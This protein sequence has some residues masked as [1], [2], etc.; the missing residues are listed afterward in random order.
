M[1]YKLTIKRLLDVLFSFFALLIL[2]PIFIIVTIALVISTRGYP[3]FFQPRPGKNGK[4]FKIIKFKT[5]NEKC[6]SSGIILNDVERLTKIGKFLRKTSFDE[7]PQIINILSGKMSLIGPRPLLIEYISLYDDIQIR[8]LE[9]RPG[10]TGWAQVNG[11][12]AISWE[13]KFAYDIY[14]IDNCTFSLDFI[15][16]LKTFN[17]VIKRAD[18][19]K[20]TLV[21]MDLFKGTKNQSQ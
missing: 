8:R 7:L 5:M 18:I 3:F 1:L 17:K 21:T 12:N 15:I 10:I 6:D 13:Q 16:L 9:A 4:I 20:D 2:S 19:N 11:R 14:Y